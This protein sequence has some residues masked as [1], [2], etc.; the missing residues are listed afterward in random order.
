[1]NREGTCVAIYDRHV[2]A[3]EALSQL[4][5][6]GFATDDASIVGRGCVPEK[7]GLDDDVPEPAWG[8]TGAFWGGL[9]EAGSA[10]VFVPD[11]GFLVIGGPLTHW[12]L[13]ALESRFVESGLGSL[14]V[15]LHGMGLS[16]ES[17]H[18]YEAEVGKS[19]CLLVFPSF[20]NDLRELARAL[21]RT[22]P[23]RMKLH[24]PLKLAVHN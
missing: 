23:R 3:E 13:G 20:D 6:A 12:M 18:E 14:G 10:T 21:R 4:R 7:G 9:W 15:A 22:Q 8:K 19:R 11:L 2:L 16:P 5:R 24:G 17:A 1:M